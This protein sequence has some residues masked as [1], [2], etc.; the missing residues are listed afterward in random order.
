MTTIT[1]LDRAENLK[2]RA[3]S[4]D[5]TDSDIETLIDL[6]DSDDEEARGVAAKALSSH[7]KDHA[8]TLQ[9][10]APEFR[11]RVTEPDQDSTRQSYL[12][13]TLSQIGLI[14]PEEVVPV[15]DTLFEFTMKPWRYFS[16]TDAL[17]AATVDDEVLD[18]LRS[19]TDSDSQPERNNAHYALSRVAEEAPERIT[20]FLHEFVGVVDD[21]SEYLKIRGHAAKTYGLAAA[22]ST[23]VRP[24][25][26]SLST[27]L[28]S[29][30]STAVE[31]ALASLVVLTKHPSMELAP[32][33]YNDR[34][35]VLAAGDDEEISLWSE[36]KERVETIQ[37][38]LAERTKTAAQTTA[39]GGAQPAGEKTQVFDGPGNTRSSPGT[40]EADSTDG[41]DAA[42]GRD[43]DDAG[44]ST[45]VS[46]CP[47]CGE[48]LRQWSDPSFC[49]GCGFELS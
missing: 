20:P 47:N 21:D 45:A 32:G 43:A 10:Y 3:G 29:R 22:E 19:R 33:L 36:D 7:S 49:S 30:E 2:D 18:L 24:E 28:R 34:L 44:G 13:E 38:Y 26:D 23:S 6:L 31:G 39:S 41:T 17:V 12:G 1:D 14:A 9:G 37:E 42:G 48:D 40:S 25:G 46:F 11:D 15:A 27:L 4:D 5:F 16:F 8:A 35:D